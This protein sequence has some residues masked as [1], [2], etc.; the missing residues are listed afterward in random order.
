V[1]VSF[2]P[3]FRALFQR[4]RYLT[5]YLTHATALLS[6]YRSALFV[7][8]HICMSRVPDGWTVVQHACASPRDRTSG[9]QTRACLSADH[10]LLQIIKNRSEPRQATCATR[11]DTR[12]V[13]FPSLLSCFISSMQ[14][15]ALR[16]P[17]VLDLGSTRVARG[18]GVSGKFADS[19]PAGR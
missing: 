18:V 14:L 10:L 11:V 3:S 9:C 1:L 13:S 17:D 19:A 4:L 2:C 6:M 7:S 8:W 12:S 16:G 5:R 15:G